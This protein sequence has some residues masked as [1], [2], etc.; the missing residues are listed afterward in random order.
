MSEDCHVRTADGKLSCVEVRRDDTHPGTFCVW[1]MAEFDIR[2]EMDG[3][4]VGE[5]IQLTYLELTDEEFDD[6]GDFDGW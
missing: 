3:M 4:E 6:L 1:K 2:A 5:S